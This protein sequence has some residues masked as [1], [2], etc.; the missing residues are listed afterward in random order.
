MWTSKDTFNI[1]I[2]I[3]IGLGISFFAAY[4][5]EKRAY[6]RRENDLFKKYGFLQSI[7]NKFD[8]QHWNINDGKIAENPVES[9]MTLKYKGGKTFSF[10]WEVKNS[11][12]KGSGFIFW[13]EV[14]HGKVSFFEG[15]KSWFDYR[16]VYHEKITHQGKEYDAIFVNADDQRTKYVMLR[17]S[18]IV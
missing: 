7:E 15:K 17:E 18:T 13:D 9:Y 1:I 2:E 14:F 8:W 16:S 12:E 10:K 6:L 4:I 11:D 5:Y 3:G